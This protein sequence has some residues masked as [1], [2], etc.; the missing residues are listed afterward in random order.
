MRKLLL[1][2]AGLLLC[3]AVT[4]AQ[5]RTISGKVTDDKGSPIPNASVVIKGTTTGTTTNASGDFQLSVPPTARALVISSVGMAQQEIALGDRNTFT[6]TLRVDDRDMQEVVVVG[7]QQRR[8]RDE[9]GAISSVRGDD[10]ENLPNPSLDKALQGR[11]AGVVVQANNGIPG[12]AINVRIRG[13]GSFLAGNQPLYIVDGVQM[14]TR[15]DAGFTQSNPLAFLNPNDIESIDILKDAASAAIYGA[16]ASNGVVIITTKKGKSGKTKFQFNTYVGVAQPLKKLDIL[17]AQEYAEL[18]VQAYLNSS[19]TVTPTSAKRTFLLNE[20]RISTPTTITEKSLDSIIAQLPTYD[21]QD[22]A[23]QNGIIQNYELS[24]SGGNDR[25][26]FRVAASY[27]MQEAVVTKADF[28]RGTVKFDLTNKA[29]DRLTINTSVNL[30]NF[31][32]NLP[33]AVEGSFLGSPAFAASTQLPTSPIYNPDGTFAGIPPN[34]LPGILNQNIIS[35]AEFNKG[36]QRTNQLVG[37]LSLDYKLNSWLTFRS[38]YGLDYRLVQG[39]L[40]RDPRTPDAFNRKGLG[41]VQSNWNT[42]IL[43]TQTLN[44]NQS[45]ADVHRLDGVVGFE[46]RRENNEGI[47]A[48]GDGFPTFQFTTLNTAANPVSVGEF[49]QG[50]KR[51]GVFTNV[52]YSYDGRYIISGTLRYD[53]SS[54]FGENNR[55]GL[56]PSVKVAWNVSNENFLANANWLSALKLRLSWGQTGNDQIG[57]YDALALYNGGLVYNNL[58]GITFAQFPNP[59]LQWEKNQTTNLG[60]DFGFFNNRINGSVE[61]YQKLTK[62]L[63]L[64]QQVG[65]VTGLSGFTQNVGE[66]ENKGI[67]LTLG[68]ALLKSRVPNGFNWNVNFVFAYNDNRVKSLYAGLKQ[69]PGD[70][71][72]AVG[73][74]LGSI[75]T[76]EYAGVNPANG[77]PMW[78]DTLRNLTYQ[79]QARDRVYIGDIQPEYS[80]GLS[81]TLS[82]KGFTMDIFFQ[83]EYGRLAQ[84]QQVNFL[85]E[86]IS[87]LNAVQDVYAKRWTT[88]GQLTSFPRQNSVGTEAKGSGALTG[89]RTWFKG[90]YI[91]LKNVTLSYD[92]PTS[93]S[94]R[95]RLSNARLY[96]QA[97]NIWTL[98]DWYGY[99][100]EFLG[101][102]LGIV[103]QSKNVTVGL[104]VGF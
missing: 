13:T 16:Q 94:G 62:S 91:R 27:N 9:A 92:L 60:L 12:G 96:V 23:F 40:Y 21:W 55:Y 80:G 52:N 3:T 61:L 32:Q 4:F 41:T 39:K 69:L 15:D 97:T 17:N 46:F 5:D 38:F 6:V 81:N 19:P 11:A 98:S 58:S 66:I 25:T 36:Y 34:N 76:Q 68:G 82:Y 28:T 33:F 70:P 100:V 73:K 20:V 99:D 71:G 37:N 74:R 22:A 53:G 104:Q 79:V 89:S 101:T 64:S 87:R 103:P 42:N 93:I 14:N 18:R 77:R 54:R 26:T 7:Y 50:F 43:T 35:V 102:G 84:D 57:N 56:F 63:L 86:N 72:T 1:F 30:S 85:I 31:Q 90:D 83:Y 75:F 10:I 29:T 48:S 95:L 78:Y 8:K 44:F 24:A 2:W 59:D 65:W 47:S 67:E 88:P 49:V 51:L 45:I